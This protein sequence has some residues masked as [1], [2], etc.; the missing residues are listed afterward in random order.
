[1]NLV[2]REELYVKIINANNQEEEYD[3]LANFPF[4][5]ETKRMGII[6]RHR[7]TNK[8]IFY[9]K[10]AETVMEKKVRPQQRASLVESCENLA[11]EGLRT[12]VIS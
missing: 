7:E 9:L 5:S 1:M 6:L 3:I 11:M 10:G 2:A 4:S 12:L 8:I